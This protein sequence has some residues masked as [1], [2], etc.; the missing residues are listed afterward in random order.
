M[1]PIDSSTIVGLL[2]RHP[3]WRQAEPAVIRSL[4]VAA[5]IELTQRVR[6]QTTRSGTSIAPRSSS[7]LRR[8]KF[9][10]PRNTEATNQPPSVMK[11]AV[12]AR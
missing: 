12:A 2:R 10:A 7:G 4:A 5:R 6:I 3:L 1:Y 8:A 9:E 11:R